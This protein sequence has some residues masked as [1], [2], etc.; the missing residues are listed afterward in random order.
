MVPSPLDSEDGLREELEKSSLKSLL[1][2]TFTLRHVMEV[3]A[4]SG[5]CPLPSTLKTGSGC[6][7]PLH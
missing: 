2:M 1:K 4:C 5:D 6:E 7:R 3:G